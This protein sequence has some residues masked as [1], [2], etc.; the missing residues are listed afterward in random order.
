[1]DS[2]GVKKATL[3]ADALVD[4]KRNMHVG[5]MEEIR[6]IETVSIT[7]AKV[8]RTIGHGKENVV[9]VSNAKAACTVPDKAFVNVKVGGGS[10]AKVEENAE[11]TTPLIVKEGSFNFIKEDSTNLSLASGGLIKNNIKYL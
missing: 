7:V 8:K 2:V 10:T 9:K 3:K 6:D 4:E 5:N 11:D 1:M